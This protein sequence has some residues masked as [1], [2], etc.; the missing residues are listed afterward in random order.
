MSEH[1]QLHRRPIVLSYKRVRR[2]VGVIG[3]LLPVV[4]GPGGWLFA[5]VAIQ[6]NLSA[7]YHT[8]MRDWLVG[9]LCALGTFLFCYRGHD[10]IEDWTANLAALFALG[11]A[12]FPIDAHSDPLH[13]RSWVGL[14]H[15][16]CGGG[17]FLTLAAY[18]LLHFPTP[19]HGDRRSDIDEDLPEPHPA[20]RNLLYRAS[21]LAI[22]LSM[23]VMGVYLLILPVEWKVWADQYHALFWLEWVAV[24]SFASSWLIKGRV[25]LADAIV[26]LLAA[27]QQ[28]LQEVAGGKGIG[29]RL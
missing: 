3:L 17:F 14:V 19:M 22:L 27:A 12:M 26:G 5:D 10:R 2:A 1:V 25:I 7:Y 28:K 6:D 16:F 9:L 15:T 13:P 20:Q 8:P 23:A 21:G 29:R 18:A 24:W 11:L 4:L